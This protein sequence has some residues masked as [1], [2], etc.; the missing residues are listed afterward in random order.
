M[1]LQVMQAMPN[2]RRTHVVPEAGNTR[3]PPCCTRNMQYRRAEPD[4]YDLAISFRQSCERRHPF[5]ANRRNII[6]IVIRFK[7]GGCNLRG[8][9]I[10]NRR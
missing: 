8:G 3:R 4:R 1:L 10:S 6:P 9:A 2:T 7:T 5:I